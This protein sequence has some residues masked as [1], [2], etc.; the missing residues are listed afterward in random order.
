[1]VYGNKLKL[2]RPHSLYLPG[3]NGMSQRRNSVLFE[4]R[5]KECECQSGTQDRY[6][7]FMTEKIR[8]S[9]YVVFVPVRE[10]HPYD[11]IQFVFQVTKVRKNYIYSGLSLLRKQHT[12]I[13]DHDLLIELENGHVSTD[14][15]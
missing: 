7:F 10:D 2:E 12:A 6:V 11:A 13:D 5:L 14:L 4:F 9:P 15:S 3:G 1:M 8:H